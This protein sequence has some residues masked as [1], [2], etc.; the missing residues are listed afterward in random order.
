MMPITDLF[1]I[2]LGVGVVIAFGVPVLVFVWFAIMPE[3]VPRPRAIPRPRRGRNWGT[4]C[5]TERPERR[6]V[7]K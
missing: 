1:F 2:A 7:A 4:M 3:T 6:R 5:W